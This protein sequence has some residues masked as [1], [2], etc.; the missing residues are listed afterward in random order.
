MNVVSAKAIELSPDITVGNV[1]QRVSGVSTTRSGSGDGQYAII[2]GMDKRYS[3][4]SVNG[5]ILPS[6]DDKNRSVPMD[7]FPADMIERLEVVKA[8][9]PSMDADAIGGVVGATELEIATDALDEHLRAVGHALAL[10]VEPRQVEGG[11]GIA[12]VGG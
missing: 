10:E 1:L 11:L 7:M 6:P 4:T 5:I 8:L 9:T 2:R 12:E 3:Y